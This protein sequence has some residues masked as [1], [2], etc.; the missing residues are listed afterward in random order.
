M[1]AA[2]RMELKMIGTMMMPPDFTI[3]NMVASDANLIRQ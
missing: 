2:A 3:S 1:I